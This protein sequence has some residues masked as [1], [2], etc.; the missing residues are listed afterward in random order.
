MKFIFFNIVVFFSLCS[1]SNI[2]FL[3]ETEEGVEFLRNKTVVYV[4]GWDNIILNEVLFSKLGENTEEKYVLSAD[5]T[6]KQTKRSINENQVAQKIDYKITIVYNL[7]DLSN[8]C[9]NFT[10]TQTSDFSFTPKSS[11]YNFASD[12]LLQN[13]YEEAISNNVSSFISFANEEL[14]SGYCLDEN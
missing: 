8:K 12:F 9:I 11:G 7:K 6:E 13:L 14:A 2:N 5:V 10:N 4:T 3:L 1:C